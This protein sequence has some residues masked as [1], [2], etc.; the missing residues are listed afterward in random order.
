MIDSEEQIDKKTFYQMQWNMWIT[1]AGRCEF[2]S[3]NPDF[4]E[5]LRMKVLRILADKE[6]QMEF[7]IRVTKA[8]DLRDKIIKGLKAL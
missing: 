5:R 4:P 6:L 1:G 3:Y 2:V 8:I 7:A